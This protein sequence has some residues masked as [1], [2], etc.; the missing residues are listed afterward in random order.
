M[1]GKDLIK[2][3]QDQGME[4]FDI[5]VTTVKYDADNRPNWIRND[6]SVDDIGYS[7]KICLLGLTP[8]E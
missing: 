4:D 1:K 7:S 6:I 2:L 8:R 5:V 3:I